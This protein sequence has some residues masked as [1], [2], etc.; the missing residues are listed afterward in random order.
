MNKKIA[1]EEHFQLPSYQPDP[2]NL[3]GKITEQSY[4]AELGRRLGDPIIRLAEMD[5]SGIELS[6]L[7]LTTPGIQGEIDPIQAV[8]RARQMNDELFE[9]FIRPYS[10]RFAG[11]AALPL[12]DPKAAVEE[13]TR[14]VRDMGFKG[15][16]INGFSNNGGPE[17]GEY[18]DEE[19]VLPF[20]EAVAKL[21]VPV[22]IHPRMPLEGQRRI[23]DG[24][25]VLMGSAWGFGVETATHALR[26]IL[27]GLFDRFPNIKIVL[28]HFGET[29][30]Y[31]ASRID[32]RLQ[33][34]TRESR[35]KQK[36]KVIDYLR[37]NFYFTTSG[38]S[39]DQALMNAVSEIGTDH[40]LFSADYPFE[41]L[42]E[43]STWFDRSPLSES[44]RQKIAYQ[45]AKALLKL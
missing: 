44:D 7:S 2:V 38:F 40:L 5:Q 42:R 21:E 22:Y 33:F 23:Y 37:K 30:P 16:M 8:R 36:G 27:S 9:T 17:K 15:A 4:I 34:H 13:M 26:L 35:G 45:N 10:N 39:H 41:D 1:L 24:Y 29:L 43:A 6:V 31:A 19:K 12:Q 32:H 11:F 3:L 25:P 18:L 20:W 28:G 14:V